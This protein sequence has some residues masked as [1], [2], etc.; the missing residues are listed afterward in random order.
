MAEWSHIIAVVIAIPIITILDILASLFPHKKEVQ[1]LSIL[2]KNKPC[3]IITF[4]V[5]FAMTMK[6]GNY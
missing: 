1:N 5:F 2:K 4:R 3:F 6:F